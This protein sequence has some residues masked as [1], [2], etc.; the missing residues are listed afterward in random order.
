MDLARWWRDRRWLA[1]LDL[2]DQLQKD[3]A[4]RLNEAILNNPEQAMLIAERQEFTDPDTGDSPPWSPRV[5]DYDLTAIMLRE[6]LHTLHAI[7]GE[8]RINGNRRPGEIPTFP[9]PRT[10]VDDAAAILERRW[11]DT[12]L[13]KWGFKPSDL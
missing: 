4:T 13:T 5:A 2:I 3:P 11:I 7:R 12:N 6:V 1:L 8:L 9:E 10:A